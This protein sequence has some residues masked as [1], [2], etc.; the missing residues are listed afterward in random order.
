[1]APD[2]IDLQLETADGRSIDAV[3]TVPDGRGPWPG[4]VVV[5]E[6]FGIDEEMH[7][8]LRHLAAMGYLAIMPDLYTHGG[9]RRC[10]IGT[11]KSLRTG[12]GRAYA[13][14]EA[15]RRFML[16]EP[17]CTRAVGVLGFC[18][19]GG[20]ALMTAASG[21]DVASVSYGDLPVDLIS[22]LGGS[23]P[24][25]ASYGAKDVTKKRAAAKLETAL[26]ELEIPHDVKEYP[27]AGHVFMNDE[28]NGWPWLRPIVRVAH[29]GPDP[30]AAA[31]AWGR[32]ES[33][34]AAHLTEPQRPP[35]VLPSA[36]RSD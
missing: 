3:M 11:L 19:G 26:T 28:L 25:V 23:C 8:H 30:V 33:F 15:A 9:M 14:I 1:M 7:K 34:F 6:L 24:V 32:I 2:I 27:D 4:I 35:A 5:H 29:F 16:D 17:H 21:F 20:F 36:P 31:D 13:D 10:L 22:K 18:M 12:R